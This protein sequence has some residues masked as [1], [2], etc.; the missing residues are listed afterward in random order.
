MRDW[1]YPYE[2]DYGLAGGS[3]LLEKRLEI[4]DKQKEELV[5]LRRHIRSGKG[6]FFFLGEE[7]LGLKEDGCLL[8][9]RFNFEPDQNLFKEFSGT[10]RIPIGQRMYAPS[11]EKIFLERVLV[12]SCC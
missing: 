8:K 5:A 9:M 12:V 11:F 6:L 10:S 3:A 2:F 1:S 7:F 4:S